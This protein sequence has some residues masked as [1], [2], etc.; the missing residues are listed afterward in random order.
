MVD[1]RCA[2]FQSQETD[3]HND[4]GDMVKVLAIHC[5]SHGQ[6]WRLDLDQHQANQL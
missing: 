2:N 3:K 6:F 4:H 1:A 5:V